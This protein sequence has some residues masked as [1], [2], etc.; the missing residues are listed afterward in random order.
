MTPQDNAAYAPGIMGNALDPGS[1]ATSYL[2][3]PPIA[4]GVSLT[5]CLS[6]SAMYLAQA[7]HCTC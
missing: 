5:P 3:G 7:I 4:S 2:I 1:P 6:M